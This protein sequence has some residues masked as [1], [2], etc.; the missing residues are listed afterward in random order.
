MNDTK[1]LEAYVTR[2]ELIRALR[3]GK[4]ANQCATGLSRWGAALAALSP[5]PAKACAGFVCNGWKT[6]DG[7]TM[8]HHNPARE[9]SSDPA[10]VC[11]CGQPYSA[12]QQE[13]AR[14]AIRERRFCKCAG[15]E[16]D[17]PNPCCPFHGSEG[18][19]QEQA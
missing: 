9:C 3:A 8:F 16:G 17:D 10:C 1:Q 7:T 2:D 6:P 19:Q 5:A 12:H 14:E 18:D 11:A 4:D 15:Y 13:Q